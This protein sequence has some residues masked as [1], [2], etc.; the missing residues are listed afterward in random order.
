MPNEVPKS[1]DWYSAGANWMVGLST[2]AIGAGL[3]FRKD[4][5]DV[6]GWV[7]G[8]FILAGV[9]FT[10]AVVFGIRLYFWLAT[11]VNR[12]E[13]I[14]S[15]EADP[16]IGTDAPL[17][18]RLKDAKETKER[19]KSQIL[20][21]YNVMLWSFFIGVGLGAVGVLFKE[22]ARPPVTKVV[23]APS[24]PWSIVTVP[25][26]PTA[27]CRIPHPHVLLTNAENG[28]TWYMDSTATA[29]AVWRRIAFDS[30]GAGAMHSH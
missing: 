14:P 19:S 21:S 28:E 20:I 6:Q 22:L 5:G 2:A 30:V 1:L 12:S 16:H 7:I 8:L 3:A 24:R 13:L 18:K 29:A 23:A 17:Q 9:S 26:C 15:L 10:I 27:R 25:C 11:L 4:A